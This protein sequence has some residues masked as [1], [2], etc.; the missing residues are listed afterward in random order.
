LV[1][2]R[3]GILLGLAI[4]AAG[5]ATGWV[6]RNRSVHHERERV[7]V[8]EPESAAEATP[9]ATAAPEPGATHDDELRRI[10]NDPK[11]HA[12]AARVRNASNVGGQCEVEVDT[13]I[14]WFRVACG[15]DTPSVGDTF[16]LFGRLSPDGQIDDAPPLLRPAWLEPVGTIARLRGN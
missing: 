2:N 11:A 3:Q 15:S 6:A 7:Q 4:F 16:D 5:V 10:L 1:R 14:S 12:L 9:S 13:N 8:A